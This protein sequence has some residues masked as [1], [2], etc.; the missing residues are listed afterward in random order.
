MAEQSRRTD[1]VLRGEER[2]K[3]RFTKKNTKAVVTQG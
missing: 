2:K 3:E 1:E